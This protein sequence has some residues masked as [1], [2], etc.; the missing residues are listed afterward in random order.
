MGPREI[1]PV[2]FIERHSNNIMAKRYAGFAKP[3]ARETRKGVQ[4]R[5]KGAR[6]RG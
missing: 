2:F 3:S 6:R 1:A 5:R 4:G